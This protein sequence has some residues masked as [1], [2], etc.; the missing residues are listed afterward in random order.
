MNLKKV[1]SSNFFRLGKLYKYM[2]GHNG[3]IAG[4][5]FKNLFNDQKI[6]DIDIFFVD[7]ED[8][9]LAVDGF[10]ADDEYIR[11]YEN[12]NVICFKE[13]K[14]GMN[15]ELI[16]KTFK[17]PE[18]MVSDFDFTIVKCALIKEDNLEGDGIEYNFI[19]SSDFFEDLHQHK[20]VIDDK[21]ILPTNTFDR[22]LKYER[23]GFR[24]CRESKI[25]LIE[26]LR[27]LVGEIDL[28]IDLYNGID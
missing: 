1:S 4:G 6:K 9:L 17:S 10:V 20:L 27:G 25:K 7:E 13:I 24:L 15:V 26:S 8:F 22:V 19:Y 18:D 3:Y 11:L 12:K 5:C 28:S 14:T 21:I 23:Y 2:K 16:R